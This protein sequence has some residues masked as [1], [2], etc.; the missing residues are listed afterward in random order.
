MRLLRYHS[1]LL[2]TSI[3]STTA[4]VL[5][6]LDNGL[7]AQV[8]DF[9]LPV[10]TTPA[11]QSL[12]P[13]STA[14]PQTSATS[15]VLQGN[16]LDNEAV[17]AV[18]GVLGLSTNSTSTDD[19]SNSASL[20]SQDD[21]LDTQAIQLANNTLSVQND[22][23]TQIDLQSYQQS[24]PPAAKPAPTSTPPPAGDNGLLAQGDGSADMDFGSSPT[25]S[26]SPLLSYP[27]V[28]AATTTTTPPALYYSSL[29]SSSST[30]PAIPIVTT[31][32]STS[33]APSIITKP[34]PPSI[35]PQDNG[36]QAQDSGSINFDFDPASNTTSSNEPHEQHDADGTLVVP[37]VQDTGLQSQDAS[38]A[39]VVW[40]LGEAYD[41]GKGGDVNVPEVV[42]GG[43][44]GQERMRRDSR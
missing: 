15:R 21:S 39:N 11:A 33:A 3:T 10:P 14:V 27:A 28:G 19:T 8:S 38:G 16:L 24:T 31:T 40:T 25:S 29:S 1:V 34:T 22:N 18:N 35:S 12:P 37:S 23:A 20:E 7:G 4:A 43:I 44:A 32:T 17:A 2:L 42:N 5:P 41:G 13:T 9:Q 6:R 36:L 30:P 26:S